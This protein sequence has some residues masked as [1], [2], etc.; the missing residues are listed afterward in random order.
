MAQST[1]FPP[2]L[3]LTLVLYSDLQRLLQK[4]IMEHGHEIGYEI[5]GN[6]IIK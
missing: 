6:K 5:K 2:T 4:K 1:Y 3:S